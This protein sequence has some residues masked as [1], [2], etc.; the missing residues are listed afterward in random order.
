MK[1][2]K[3]YTD[4]QLIL[5]L[6]A[7]NRNAFGCIYK[8]HWSSLFDT[9]YGKLQS[10]EAAEEVVQDL[11]LYLWCKREEITINYSFSTYIHT[12]LK[13]RIYNYLR[14]EIN[15]KKNIRL[16]YQSKVAY[17]NSV[18]ES[19][20]YNELNELIEKEINSLPEKCKLVF[21]LSREENFSFKEIANELNISISTV[22]K[23]IVKALK[24]LRTKL[25]DHIA[26][27]IF[28]FLS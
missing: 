5:L 12:A 7:G 2:Y 28:F 10:T 8:R 23:H 18:G 27:L 24:I 1:N 25:K 14:D 16:V 17:N 11:F 20:A 15:R 4:E 22:E 19:I 21:T 26:L 3:G 6:K 9:A 13:Y